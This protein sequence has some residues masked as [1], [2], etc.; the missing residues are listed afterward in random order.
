MLACDLQATRSRY[1]LNVLLQLI[2]I[3]RDPLSS[4]HVG[5]AALLALRRLSHLLTE[6]VKGALCA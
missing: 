6:T 3:A 4:I 5:N 1:G 2:K